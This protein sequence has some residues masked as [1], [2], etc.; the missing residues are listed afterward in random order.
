MLFD[1]IHNPGVIAGF[2]AMATAQLL[3]PFVQ[4]FVSREWD[5]F[6]LIDSGGMPSSHSAMVTAVAI[7][8]GMTS[9]FDTPVFAASV[10]LAVIV[11]YDAANVRWQSGLHAQR[12]N[13]LIRDVFSG[14]QI[15]EELLKE[16]IGHTPR[17]VYAGVVWGIIIAVVVIEIWMA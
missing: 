8:I 12:I 9:G 1:L 15:D 17:Q 14:Q 11:T 6:L 16:V 4:Y 2:V 10:A 13:Q 3:K 7:A 5:W